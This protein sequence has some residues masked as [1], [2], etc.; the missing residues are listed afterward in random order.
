MKP[1]YLFD[2]SAFIHWFLNYGP[3]VVK[4]LKEKIEELVNEG[5]IISVRE[6]FREIVAKTDDLEKWARK[7]IS[8][9][10]NPDK[11]VVEQMFYVMKNY[12]NLI[13]VSR[14]KP[15][16]DPWIIAQAMVMHAQ[17]NMK[18]LKVV[19]NDGQLGASLRKEGV[20][21]LGLKEFMKQEN[22]VLRAI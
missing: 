9:F 5:R 3:D 19:V 2:T 14:S 12:S 4:G 21:V 22:I 1:V 16:S 10:V 13:H 8:I 6:A 17:R 20:S 18:N 11:Q 7:N 15:Q